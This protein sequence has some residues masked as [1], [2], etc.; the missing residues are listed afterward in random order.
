MPGVLVKREN[1]DTETHIEGRL[2]KRNRE[3]TVPSSTGERLERDA[4]LTAL[5]R[6]N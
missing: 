1:E 5:R 2:Q 6:N 3:E 4:S